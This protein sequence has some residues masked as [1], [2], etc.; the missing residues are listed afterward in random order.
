MSESHSDNVYY[1]T[2]LPPNMFEPWLRFGDVYNLPVPTSFVCQDKKIA[3]FVMFLLYNRRALRASGSASVVLQGLMCVRT[4]DGFSWSI[5]SNQ[6]L[7]DLVGKRDMCAG[8]CTATSDP[9]QV[10]YPVLGK[11][12]R[13]RG[14]GA[15]ALVPVIRN[16][17][18]RSAGAQ[19]QEPKDDIDEDNVL[20]VKSPANENAFQCFEAG[21]K[22]SEQQDERDAM[23]LLY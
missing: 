9:P 4:I 11:R 5:F 23:Q 22:W 19:A 13:P 10:R 16:S 12:N 17:A 7:R 1:V 15:G 3:A 21:I 6:P 2:S 14:T 20:V 18:I 8:V